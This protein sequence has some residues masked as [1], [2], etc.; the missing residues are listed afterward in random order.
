MRPSDCAEL[1][2]LAGQ[3]WPGV[4]ATELRIARLSQKG[5]AEHWR[6]GRDGQTLV[7][8]ATDSEPSA[9]RV[10][11][12]LTALEGE[13]FAPRLLGSRLTDASRYLIAMED[14]GEATPEP[15]QVQTN[16][17]EYVGV[18]QR[19]HSHKRFRDAVQVA[20]HA[21]SR[22]SA[23]T[24]AQ[25]ECEHLLRL[26]HESRTGLPERAAIEEE[27]QRLRRV[28]PRDARFQCAEGWLE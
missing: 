20:G 26:H 1:T 4:R 7:L 6:L 17:E 23:T 11:S 15:A 24:S 19:L 8:R 22:G 25:A 18:L 21:S 3:A 16:V 2:G 5:N 27:W 12:A 28:S 10:I 14:F 13:T 9:R